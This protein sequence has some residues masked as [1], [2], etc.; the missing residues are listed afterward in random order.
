MIIQN[1]GVKVMNEWVLNEFSKRK[2][3]TA[4]AKSVLESIIKY[5]E[6]CESVLKSE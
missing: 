3:L 6:K 5:I 1:L 2:M 4:A